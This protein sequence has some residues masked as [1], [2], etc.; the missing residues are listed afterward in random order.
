MKTAIVLSGGG[1][2]GAFQA[3][4]LQSL[5]Q[6]GV[7]PDFIVGTSVG[8]L[9]AA[10]MSHIGMDGVMGMWRGIKRRGDVLRDHWWKIPFNGSGRYSMAPLKSKVSKL[11]ERP[12][13]ADSPE[14]IACFVDLKTTEVIYRSNLTSPPSDFAQAVLASASIPFYM[15]PVDGYLADGGVREVAPIRYACQRLGWHGQLIVITCQPLLRHRAADPFS[16]AWPRALSL[17]LRALDIRDHETLINDLSALVREQGTEVQATEPG[18]IKARVYAPGE[19]LYG[20][21]DFTPQHIT[22]GLELGIEVGRSGGVA[23]E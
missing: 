1:A 7:V 21:F 4:V 13:I 5:L 12:L 16:E 22:R 10:G 6:Q 2:K 8:A 14:A 11:V 18:G 20:T 3:G 23:W 9:N 17:G 19:Y 15:E